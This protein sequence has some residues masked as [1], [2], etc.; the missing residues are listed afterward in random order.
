MTVDEALH[1]LDVAPGSSLEEIRRAWMRKSR[2]W[3]PALEPD[4]LRRLQEA[5]DVLVAD[6][7]SRPLVF[8]AGDHPEEH[9]DLPEPEETVAGPR[10][11]LLLG[12]GAAL[13]LA[14][15]L[16]LSWFQKP[17]EPPPATAMERVLRP[18]GAFAGYASAQ[19]ALNELCLAPTRSQRE[20]C[21]LAESVL[22][23]ASRHECA[24]AKAGRAKLGRFIVV[25]DVTLGHVATQK[26]T[27][28]RENLDREIAACW[29]FWNP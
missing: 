29:K 13:L 11:L 10:W 2:T 25:H 4:G 6:H 19:E 22:R 18:P 24:D 20:V 12:G 3:N 9:E 27:S 8:P 5:H 23:A 28:L 21:E 1:R 15:W 7:A 16:G 17:E 26:L 14:L